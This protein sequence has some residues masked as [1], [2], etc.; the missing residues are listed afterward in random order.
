MNGEVS[1]HASWHRGGGGTVGLQTQASAPNN[2]APATR[3][4]A[5]PLTRGTQVPLC[6]SHTLSAQNKVTVLS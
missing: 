6:P 5:L 4:L 2:S 3:L 1:K